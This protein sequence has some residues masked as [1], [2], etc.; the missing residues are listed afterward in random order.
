MSKKIDLCSENLLKDYD[1]YLVVERRLAP[2]TIAVYLGE[3]QRYLEYATQHELDVSTTSLQELNHYLVSRSHQEQLKKRSLA[4]I[5]SALR[6]F[7]RFLVDSRLRDENPSELLE[8]PKLPV[9]I[10]KAASYSEVAM[11]LDSIDG[12]GNPHLALRDRALFETIYSA[13]LRVS[14][15]SA[16]KIEDVRFDQEEIRVLGKG[17]KERLIPLGAHAAQLL[18]RYLEE[19]RSHLVGNHIHQKALFVGRR[20]QALSRAAIWKR[21]T[22]YCDRLGIEAKVHTLRHSFATHLLRGGAD[23]RSVQELLGHA[24]IRTTQIYTHADTD[25]LQQAFEEHHPLGQKHKN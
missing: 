12:F 18:Q 16:L 23:L 14:E 3:A 9:T 17:N 6:S 20:G 8:L 10:P 21:F 11:L 25:D 13:G 19:A 1:D 2:G 5:V 15:A 24:D 4:K 7:H 22:Q